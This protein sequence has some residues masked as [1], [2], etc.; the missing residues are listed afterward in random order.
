[1][2]RFQLT[3]TLDGA[4]IFQTVYCFDE[5]QERTYL[6]RI[7]TKNRDAAFDHELRKVLSDRLTDSGIGLFTCQHIRE[8]IRSDSDALIRAEIQLSVA[9]SNLFHN[10]VD[11]KDAAEEETPESGYENYAWK[12]VLLS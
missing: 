6:G 3:I 9:N 1:M 7:A 2:K 10:F 4:N 5:Q 11:P 8:Q 12:C